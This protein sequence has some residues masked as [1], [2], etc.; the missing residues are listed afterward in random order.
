M[1]GTGMTQHS[2]VVQFYDFADKFWT[3]ES[4]SL[5]PLF[6]LE[7]ELNAVLEGTDV[8]ELDGHE[9]AVDGSDGFL[10]LYGPDAD[11]LFALIEPILRKSAVMAGADAT[12]RYG[13]P[14]EADLKQ[15][16]ITI[17]QTTH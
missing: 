14:D 1:V 15:R 10:F 8:G 9:I 2:V 16:H 4:R 5:D 17:D 7:D 13:E 6:A 11:A 12:L 3:E